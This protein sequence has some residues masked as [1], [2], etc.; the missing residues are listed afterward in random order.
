MGVPRTFNMADIWE[1]AADAVPGREAL[2]VGRQR[3]TYA[4]L[5]DRANR[6]ANHLAGRG[7]GPGDHVALYLE[8]CPEY[9]EAMLAAWKLRA[10]TINVNHRYVADELRYLLDDSDGCGEP[11]RRWPARCRP[12]AS[13]W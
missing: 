11:S 1:M 9:L 6:L 2:V 4:Q 7:I 13:P 3:R 10:V 5:E 8:N 12:C